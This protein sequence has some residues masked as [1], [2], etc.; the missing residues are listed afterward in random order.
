MALENGL[1]WIKTISGF[2]KG[3]MVSEMDKR[4]WQLAN[5]GQTSLW[6]LGFHLTG[7][8]Q[9]GF[10]FPMGGDIP[11]LLMHSSLFCF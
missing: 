5:G 1:E 7:K 10:I 2:T 4:K 8:N 11:T 9:D 6:Y 3:E